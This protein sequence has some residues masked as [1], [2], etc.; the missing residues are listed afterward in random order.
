MSKF[1]FGAGEIAIQAAE[2]DSSPSI[3]IVAY[4]GGVLRLGNFRYPVVLDLNGVKAA[5]NVPFLIDH[6]NATNMVVGQGDVR[7]EGDKLIAAGK[8]TGTSA[9]AKQVIQTAQNGHVYQASIGAIPLRSTL[10]EEGEKA[11][12]NGKS[13]NGPL[14]H[15]TASEIIE[16][17]IVAIGADRDGTEVDIAAMFGLDFSQPEVGNN[18][19]G[20]EDTM[21]PK[22]VMWVQAQLGLEEE[23]LKAMSPEKLTKL[24]AHYAAQATEGAKPVE[25]SFDTQR[26]DTLEEELRVT[27]IKAACGSDFADLC[28]K[29]ISEKWAESQ[30]EAALCEIKK[31]RDSRPQAPGIIVRGGNADANVI[32]AA[33]AIGST[34]MSAKTL[35]A[36][37]SKEVLDKAD[38]L[39]H[40][41]LKEIMAASCAA[42][43]IAT[44]S[45]GSSTEEWAKAAFSTRTFPT[46]LSNVANKSLWEGYDSRE[47]VA[48]M[49]S[50]KLSAN[51]FKTHTS[52]R[53]IAGGGME[54]VENGGEIK[55]QTM[56]DES[57]TYSVDTYG[58]LLGLTR[59]D[60]INDDLGA[61]ATIPFQMGWDAWQKREEA[62]WTL[63]LA[64]TGSFY[65]SAH[66]NLLTT[67]PLAIAG[68][69]SAVATFE[70]Q[71]DGKNRAIGIKPEYMVVP[72]ELSATA[73]GFYTSDLIV[74]GNTTAA[75]DKNIH[76]NKYRPLSTPFLSNT[77]I[78][79]YSSADW[80]LFAD[81]RAVAAYGIAYLNGKEGPTIE[82]TTPDVR[83][84]GRVF[85]AYFDFGVCQ[86]DYRG[87]VKC[88]AA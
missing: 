21:D 52:A 42:D 58:E 25:A 80:Y 29:A 70:K 60:I 31:V 72:S 23:T 28:E 32:E 36:S 87:S 51:D 78:S 2:G 62:F 46:V 49:V 76:R 41:N 54:K 26:V 33:V 82:E 8:L 13:F 79:G 73:D 40:M 88:D 37:Y 10:I 43:G 1:L 9:E 71:V 66:G 64:N 12:I 24:E 22:F 55:H 30:V 86:I 17:S 48:A 6:T 18:S 20:K 84:L 4:N 16:V 50:K 85:R 53:I 3:S 56:E 74:S 11:D 47:S 83:Y 38:G 68:L 77:S 15:V 5:S 57:Y 81:P 61:F 45:L 27:K 44:P 65:S 59:Q 35:E 34:N 63:V 39:R 69:N 7:R 14:V 75:N 67:T 19:V